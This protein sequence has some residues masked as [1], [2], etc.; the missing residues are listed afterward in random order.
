[1][2]PYGLDRRTYLAGKRAEELQIGRLQLVVATTLRHPQPSDRFAVMRECF[3]VDISHRRTVFGSKAKLAR[4]VGEVDRDVRQPQRLCHGLH[5]NGQHLARQHDGLHPRPEPRQYPG[6]IVPVAVHQPVHGAL[7][8]VAQ[9]CEGSAA[10]AA[11]IAA[12]TVP[13]RRSPLTS[14]A[15]SAAY[16]A[17]RM[18]TREM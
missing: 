2:Q 4:P 13:E 7:R 11:A 3:G 12:A 5:H 18:A 16:P 15:T 9:R 8:H 6:R 14:T 1:M 10:A 17:T